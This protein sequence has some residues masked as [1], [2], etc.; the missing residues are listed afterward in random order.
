M[1]PDALDLA[2]VQIHNSPADIAQWPATVDVTQLMMHPGAGLTFQF[3]PRQAWPDYTP[4]TWTGPIQYTVWAIVQVNG[5][6]HGSGFIQMWRDRPSTGAPILTEWQQNWA[7]DSTRWGPMVQYEPTVGDSI[8]F[9]LSAGNARGQRGVTSVR[10]RSNVVLV[11]LPANDSGVFTFQGETP[12]EPVPEPQEPIPAI[13]NGEVERILQAI[14]ES[15]Q[16]ILA[17]IEK[18]STSLNAY[19]PLLQKLKNWLR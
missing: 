8:G 6:W 17:A 11:H 7:Y 4:P 2:S 14:A 10:E 1:I 19:G 18:A 5:E 16:T 9:L 3:E 12:Q 15:Q 13:P